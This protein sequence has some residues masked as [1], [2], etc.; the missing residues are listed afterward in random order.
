MDADEVTF[1]QAFEQVEGPIGHGPLM[2]AIAWLGWLQFDSEKVT[3]WQIQ[4]W[5]HAFV[6]SPEPSDD[7]ECVDC[8]ET[9]EQTQ[10]AIH[11]RFMQMFPPSPGIANGNDRTPKR[12]ARP[13]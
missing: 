4:E 11:A 10:A 3:P 2:R 5:L 12:S 13:E 9:Q 1:W 8:E 6:S 7:D